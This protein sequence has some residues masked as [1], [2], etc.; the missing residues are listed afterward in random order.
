MHY[1]HCC[2]QRS[3]LNNG[4][5]RK[6]AL[7]KTGAGGQAVSEAPTAQSSKEGAWLLSEEEL[8]AAL[9]SKDRGQVISAMATVLRQPSKVIKFGQ[10]KIPTGKIS[11]AAL[12][13]LHA[14]GLA[15]KVY[16]K[17]SGSTG[18][19]AA[20]VLKQ[21]TFAD[22]LS[23]LKMANHLKDA[24]AL[25]WSDLR[26]QDSEDNP[27]VV[28]SAGDTLPAITAEMVE[29]FGST[30]LPLLLPSPSAI[31]E[32]VEG[33]APAQKPV[34]LETARGFKTHFKWVFGQTGER[35]IK[36]SY[37]KSRI[38][39]FNNEGAD[40]DVLLNTLVAMGLAVDTTEGTKTVKGAGS[41]ELLRPMANEDF[42]KVLEALKN[43]FAIFEVKLQSCLKGKLTHANH[44]PRFDMDVFTGVLEA[45]G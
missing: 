25:T 37:I 20:Y 42:N 22:K 32:P 41:L 6:Q 43:C 19:P 1:K 8:R 30:W 14:G 34:I 35:K 44:N 17:P 2:F 27:E 18:Y 40:W 26:R 45:M 5:L 3:Y 28:A 31:A 39:G 23:E 7:G 36:R 9:S 13:L 12:T 33:D 16:W 15:A 10:L 29:S 11:N 24:L 4:D 38:P 21:T